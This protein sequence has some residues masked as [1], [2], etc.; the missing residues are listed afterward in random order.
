MK[1]IIFTR[2]TILSRYANQTGAYIRDFCGS[3]S[4]A[5][6]NHGFNFSKTS[7]MISILSVALFTSGEERF[8]LADESETTTLRQPNGEF[9][10]VKPAAD[11]L[12]ELPKPD[13]S[14]VNDKYKGTQLVEAL[15]KIR[16]TY[17]TYRLDEP[18]QNMELQFRTRIPNNNFGPA[19]IAAD[20]ILMLKE[21]GMT[22]EAEKILA[23]FRD[24]HLK[25]S[26]MFSRMNIAAAA[27]PTQSVSSDFSRTNNE[28]QPKPLITVGDYVTQVSLF[29]TKNQAKWKKTSNELATDLI[30]IL[31]DSDGYYTAIDSY[32]STFPYKRYSPYVVGSGVNVSAIIIDTD[33]SS[34]AKTDKQKYTSYFDLLDDFIQSSA[35]SLD[36]I[37]QKLD[38]SDTSFMPNMSKELCGYAI[39]LYHS[40]YKDDA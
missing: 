15:E 10:I 28:A 24:V 11:S 4:Q 20:Y 38:K 6:K 39:I 35:V 30:S 2:T 36:E 18:S 37:M 32:V 1:K 27:T 31:P 9:D 8:A 13:Y 19:T 3:V 25:S 34:Q 7:V 14:G 23:V 16:N 5:L 33:A 17:N 40:G 26:I 22:N 21:A 29:E 12:P